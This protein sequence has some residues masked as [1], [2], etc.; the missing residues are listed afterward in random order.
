MARASAPARHLSAAQPISAH[1]QM[2]SVRLFA[3]ATNYH[4][5]RETRVNAK[6]FSNDQVTK[7]KRRSREQRLAWRTLRRAIPCVWSHCSAATSGFVGRP[8]LAMSFGRTPARAKVNPSRPAGGNVQRAARQRPRSG[9]IGPH[10]N[11]AGPIARQVSL[12]LFRPAIPSACRAFHNVRWQ[13]G[14]HEHPH[15]GIG[16]R[17]SLAPPRHQPR[18]ENA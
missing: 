11:A 13:H 3:P 17:L 12:R 10:S 7:N 2:H 1:G 15:R 18:N 14:C 4:H 8:V 9:S 16:R 6:E 5:K